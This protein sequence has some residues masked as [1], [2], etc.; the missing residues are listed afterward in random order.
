ML[1]ACKKVGVECHLQYWEKDRP[2][3]KVSR[4]EFLNKL[5]L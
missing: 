3:P 2:K 1:E 4:Q 5:L